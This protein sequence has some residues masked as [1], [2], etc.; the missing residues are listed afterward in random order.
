VAWLLARWWQKKSWLRW[1][2]P[3]ALAIMTLAGGLDVLRVLT[4]ASQYQEF[5]IHAREAA[6]AILRQAGPRALVLHAPTYNSPV[7]LT[8]RRSLLGY[9]GW[10]WSRGL[11]YSQRAADIQSIYS[12]SA[13]AETLLR[14]YGVQYVVLGPQERASFAVSERFWSRYTNIM[15]AGEYRLYKTGVPEVRTGQ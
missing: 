3:A 2:A 10:M 5:D 6:E 7:F 14:H 1:L 9:P 8:G 13:E 12:G 4:D 15:P 11:D